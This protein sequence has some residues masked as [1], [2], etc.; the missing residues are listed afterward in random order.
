MQQK[1]VSWWVA[2]VVIVL[3]IIIVGAIWYFLAQRG[4]KVPA[5]YQVEGAPEEEEMMTMPAAGGAP[6]PME[7]G[8]EGE[9]A[10]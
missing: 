10:P 2:L 7:E 6:M 1:Q 8:M 3:V 4:G 9:A 5:E